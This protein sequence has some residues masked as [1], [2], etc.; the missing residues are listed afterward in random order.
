MCKPHFNP[1]FEEHCQKANLELEK[2][3]NEKLEEVSKN[4][5]ESDKQEVKNY[6]K[7]TIEEASK[8]Q[9]DE[10]EKQIFS[11]ENKQKSKKNYYKNTLNS[12]LDSLKSGFSPE[13][14][15]LMREEK[16]YNPKGNFFINGA[17][18]GYYEN[19]DIQ[20]R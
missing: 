14:I 17:N 11:E 18:W 13:I 15:D 3:I 19:L 16:N 10:L 7:K 9:R 20:Q 1:I 8:N 12:L 6:A 5:S 2:N 4:L